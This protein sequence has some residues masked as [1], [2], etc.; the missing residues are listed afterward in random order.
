M[1]RQGSDPHFDRIHRIEMGD[2]IVRRDAD[3]PGG[4]T[5][6]RH[7][8]LRRVGTQDFD[9][10]GDLDVLRQIKNSEA[11]VPGPIRQQWGC[12]NTEDSIGPHRIDA[13]SN[14]R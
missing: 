6:L 7:K 5:T 14:I 4:Q 1:N 12:R 8:G 13:T 11:G 2:Q 9:L 10:I 3:E